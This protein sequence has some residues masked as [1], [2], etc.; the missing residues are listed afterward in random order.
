MSRD[1]AAL[2]CLCGACRVNILA[3]S[4]HAGPP[5]PVSGVLRQR[6]GRLRGVS[7]A[8][9]WATVR[10]EEMPWPVVNTTLAPLPSWLGSE[11]TVAECKGCQ[12]PVAARWSSGRSF[13]MVSASRVAGVAD[14][15]V[16]LCARVQLVV[17]NLTT[18]NV[19][20]PEDMRPALVGGLWAASAAE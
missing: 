18:D 5:P 10:A 16:R 19:R 12:W 11:W 8:L 3:R 15:A 9:E 4:A 1:V 6:L 2:R 20:L 14:A 7:A 17:T 13:E